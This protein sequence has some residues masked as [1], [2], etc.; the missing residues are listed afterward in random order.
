MRV[1]VVDTDEACRRTMLGML[2]HLG[3]Q[4]LL[5]VD[6]EEAWRLLRRGGVDVVITDR[7]LP[8]L[9]GLEVVRFVR[10]ASRT[11]Y[12]HVVLAMP[13]SERA[14]VPDAMP[15]GADDYLIK[16]VQLHDLRLRLLAAERV[17]NARRRLELLN[18][19]LQAAAR[20]DSLTGLGNRRSLEEQLAAETDLVVRYARRY[21]IAL[22]DVDNFK[23]Y[24]DT[25]GHQSGDR[26]LQAI[27]A[28]LAS[29]SR[30]GDEWYRYG[31]EE[32]LGIYPEQAAADARVGVERIRKGVAALGLRCTADPDGPVLTVSAGIAEMT[33]DRPD[34]E[35][36]VRRADAALYRAKHLGRD[37]VEVASDSTAALP[38]PREVG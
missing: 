29:S 24:N 23:A 14:Q 20:R 37:T 7:R 38:E 9:T 4:C 28:V 36:L 34:I 31:G 35:D 10:R 32:F 19:Q 15:A 8:G 5:A 13:M 30:A 27:A 25:H 33:V 11:G 17:S 18:A 2:T 1:L 3:H 12:V 22:L 21:S 6:G 26:A 16:P